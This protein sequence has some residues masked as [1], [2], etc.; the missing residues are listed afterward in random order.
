[1]TTKPHKCNIYSKTAETLRSPTLFTPAQLYLPYLQY[2]VT[3]QHLPAANEWVGKV[4]KF[5]TVLCDVVGCDKNLL[6][7]TLSVCECGW[8]ITRAIMQCWAANQMQTLAGI[9]GLSLFSSGEFDRHRPTLCY[10]HRRAKEV[11][12]A[13]QLFVPLSSL[14]H[15]K[16]W[17]M[18]SPTVWPVQYGN[19][20]QS[21]ESLD[22]TG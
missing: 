18:K 8:I 10:C 6:A 17:T 2:F 16:R 3:W 13:L 20:I 11:K 15:L 7:L 5:S 1:M 14:Q 12:L 21:K 22:V 4:F 9:T 19:D